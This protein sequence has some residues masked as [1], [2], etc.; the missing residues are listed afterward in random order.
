MGEWG[1]LILRTLESGLAVGCCEYGN[2]QN[3]I[4]K[5]IDDL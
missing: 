4:K 5:F 1:M 2:E 3:G